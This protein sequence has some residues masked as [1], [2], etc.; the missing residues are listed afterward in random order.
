MIYK[1]Y[2][3]EENLSLLKNNVV[4]IYGENCGLIAEIKKKLKDKNKLNK[5]LNFTQ[6]E[7]IKD[8]SLLS[9][10]IENTSLFE[11][12]KIIFITEVNDKILNIIDKNINNFYQDKI[13]LFGNVL[14]KKSK[15]R[16]F[17][18][19]RK[20]CDVVPCYKDSEINLRKIINKKLYGFKGL[21]N[22]II[23]A[24]IENSNLDRVKINNEIEKIKTFFKDKIININDLNNLINYREDSNFDI[25]KDTALIGNKG[26]TNK[27]LSTTSLELEKMPLYI[28]I[29]NQRL[30]KLNEILNFTDIKD[31]T[32]KVDFIKPPIF[33]KDKPNLIK[34]AEVW[35][36]NKIN[37]AMNKTYQLELN[38]KS[39]TNIDKSVLFKKLLVDICLIANA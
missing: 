20:T 39:M 30:N 16:S 7:I 37:T 3:I 31:I 21:N 38:I 22:Q 15:I 12:K 14:E 26:L 19:K 1:S 4:L 25:I 8:Q 10:E 17:F 9:K 24:L 29:L 27:L 32:K 23:E 35:S 36:K 18:E 6:D 34:Q 13:Y 28:N 33:W 11:D 5:I 2:L